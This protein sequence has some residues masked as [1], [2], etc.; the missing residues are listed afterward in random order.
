[1]RARRSRWLGVFA[2]AVVAPGLSG[3]AKAQYVGNSFVSSTLPLAPAGGENVSVADRRHPEYDPTGISLGGFDLFPKIETA[4]GYDDNVY[5]IKSPKRDDAYGVLA[6]SV[7]LL[8]H[9]TVSSI[10]VEAGANLQRYADETRRNQDSWHVTATGL[11]DFGGTRLSGEGGTAKATEAATSASYPTDAAD[12]VQ[13]QRTYAKVGV[14]QD[15]GDLTADV[16]YSFTRYAFDN[17]RSLQ[18]DLINQDNRNSNNHQ[19]VG[20]LSYAFNPA[21]RAYVQG[22]YIGTRYSNELLPGVENRDSDSYNLLGGVSFDISALFRG[23]VAIGYG[24][25]G[26]SSPLYSDISGLT[27]EARVEYFPTLLT[28]ITLSARRIIQDAAFLASG[29]YFNTSVAL[30]IDHE[31]YRNVLLNAQVGF[32]HDTYQGFD[33]SLN[34]IRASAGGQYMINRS[35]GLGVLVSHDSRS[36]RGLFRG[37]GFSEN[38]AQ[39]SIILQR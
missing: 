9:W 20:R 18:G 39:L 25:R 34:L 33:A 11:Y 1:M 31:L 22:D 3:A 24:R 6:P 23:A 30:R 17:V 2:A 7:R 13:Y 19:V 14:A 32:E 12:A 38:R 4:V 8:S 5:Q 36:A 35:L 29:G 21:T 26:Y 27:A 28:T 16:Y 10:G 15:I 37:S